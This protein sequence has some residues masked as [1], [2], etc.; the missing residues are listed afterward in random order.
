MLLWDPMLLA[1]RGG[2]RHSSPLGKFAVVDLISTVLPETVPRP[3]ANRELVV[4]PPRTPSV[5]A[6]TSQSRVGQSR[7]PSSPVRLPARRP[8]P[9]PVLAGSRQTRALA[10]QPSLS[11][12][13]RIGSASPH[14]LV[15]PSCNHCSRCSPMAPQGTAILGTRALHRGRD[16]QRQ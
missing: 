4:R 3:S 13:A 15:P 2:H 10:C 14:A 12:F 8:E 9:R 1:P 11:W 7:A 5:H 6:G 16:Q